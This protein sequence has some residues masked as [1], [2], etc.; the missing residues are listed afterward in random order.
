MLDGDL[1][2]TQ[3]PDPYVDGITRSDL[4]R[5]LRG[6][7]Y[8]ARM[9]LDSANKGGNA[10]AIRQARTNLAIAYNVARAENVAPYRK[11]AKR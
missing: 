11:G 10:A 8:I 5:E 4:E 9:H 6:N 1:Q 7:V 3:M 2:L